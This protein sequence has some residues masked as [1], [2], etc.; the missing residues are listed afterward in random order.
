MKLG[1]NQF[2]Q[3]KNKKNHK[4]K[5]NKIKLKSRNEDQLQWGKYCWCKK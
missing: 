1:Q 3:N 4:K 2:H 5:N